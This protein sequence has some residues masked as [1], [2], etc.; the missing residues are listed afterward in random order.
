MFV[1]DNNAPVTAEILQ[2]LAE[3]NEGDAA[4]YGDDAWTAR[5]AARLKAEFGS[6]TDVFF[7]FNGTGANVMALSAVLRPYEAVICPYTAHLNVDECGALERFAGCKTIALATDD[8]KLHPRDLARYAVR[9]SDVHHPLPRVVSISQATEYGTLYTPEEIRA[10]A[11]FVHERGLLLHIDG[12]RIA[13][14]ATALGMGLREC[15]RD[16]GA[17]FLTF[18]GT[19]NGLMF[20]EAVIFFDP[21]LHGGTAG[22]ARKQTTQLA[23][24]M[25][26]IAAQ[27]EALLDGERWRRYAQ[28]ANAMTARLAERV[29]QIAGVKITRPVEVNAIFS[30]LD[31]AAIARLQEEYFF[32]VFDEALPEVRW[33]THHATREQEV[34]RFADAIERAIIP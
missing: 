4:G 2:A 18:G 9:T 30:T 14:A 5:A 1:S 32:Y 34:D 12:A 16:L 26:Y 15:T 31:R 25:R 24:K 29:R 21:S 33:M 8:G 17:D 7:A 22:F 13:N 6:D 20:G 10:L 11:D 3:A 23:S 27:F 28:H 19:K